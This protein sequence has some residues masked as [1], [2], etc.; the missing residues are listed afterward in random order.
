MTKDKLIELLIAAFKA[1]DQFYDC[2]VC[3]FGCGTGPDW[4]DGGEEG[5]W[6][7]HE[8]DCPYRLVMC[9]LEEY[10]DGRVTS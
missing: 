1:V 8:V 2:Y 6:S 7:R 5:H 10:Q 9:A 3:N 4:D